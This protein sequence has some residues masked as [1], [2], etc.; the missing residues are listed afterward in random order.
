[1]MVIGSVMVHFFSKRRILRKEMCHKNRCAGSA[2]LNATPTF[3]TPNAM[4]RTRI[5]T[6][7][8]PAAIGPYSQAIEVPAGRMVFFSGQI[9]IDPSTQ[10]VIVGDISAQTERAMQNLKAVLE[11][12]NLTFSNVVRCGIFLVDMA[13]FAAV[14]EVYG[15]YFAAPAPARSTVA[16]AGLPKGV[17]VEIDAIAV[18]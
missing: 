7:N 11:A 4:T 15:R 5:H 6:D 18:G 10:Q 1:M 17:R 12:A 9:P 14:N 2:A 13:D 3:A 8:A 16:V